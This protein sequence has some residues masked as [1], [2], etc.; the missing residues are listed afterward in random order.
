MNCKHCGYPDSAHRSD[1]ACPVS[2]PMK[3]RNT[4]FEEETAKSVERRKTV[5]GSS[6]VQQPQPASVAPIC[7]NSL[8]HNWTFEGCRRKVCEWDKRNTNRRVR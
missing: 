6:P 7:D 3:Y 8:C 4:R 2:W 1:D 5:K